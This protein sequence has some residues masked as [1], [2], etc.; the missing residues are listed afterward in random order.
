MNGLSPSNNWLWSSSSISSASAV[1]SL[2]TVALLVEGQHI[3]ITSDAFR[4]CKILVMV[5]DYYKYFDDFR[6]G[7]RVKFDVQGCDATVV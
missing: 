1:S 2:S 3:S 6:V 4:N 5:I 7:N